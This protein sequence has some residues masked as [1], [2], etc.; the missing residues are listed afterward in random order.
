[1]KNTPRIPVSDKGSKYNIGSPYVILTTDMDIV[2][3]IK[4][5]DESPETIFLS[6][7]EGNLISL[8]EKFDPTKGSGDEAHSILL[9]FL[10]PEGLFIPRLTQHSMLNQYKIFL[11]KLKDSLAADKY[12]AFLP[13]TGE[14]N[15]N[16]EI[17][18]L[19]EDEYKFLTGKDAPTY[20][21]SE[22]EK[23]SKPPY[24]VNI[25]QVL[26]NDQVSTYDLDSFYS[27]SAVPPLH[28]Y[29][30]FGQGQDPTNQAPFRKFKIVKFVLVQDDVDN[31]MVSMTLVP[32]GP[33]S[34]RSIAKDE[35]TSNSRTRNDAGGLVTVPLAR[36]VVV[37]YNEARQSRMAMNN[38]GREIPDSHHFRIGRVVSFE[39]TNI[40]SILNCLENLF[41]KLLYSTSV[42]KERERPFVFLNPRLIGLIKKR[43]KEY[44][45]QQTL[46]QAYN[47]NVKTQLINFIGHKELLSRCG[48]EFVSEI[49]PEDRNVLRYIKGGG[50]GGSNKRVDIETI[51]MG[52]A[53]DPSKFNSPIDF[54]YSIISRLY[55]EV[56]LKISMFGEDRTGNPKAIDLTNK[57][58]AYEFL[59]QLCEQSAGTS[60]IYPELENRYVVEAKIPQ[61]DLKENDKNIYSPNF[62]NKTEYAA[63]GYYNVYVLTDYE[64]GTGIIN[65][66]PPSFKES[67]VK[68]YIKQI[69]SIS[70]GADKE[71]C[72]VNKLIYVAK[73]VPNRETT[74]WDSF[75]P[76]SFTDY[77]INLGKI[78][79]DKATGVFGTNIPDEFGLK[80]LSIVQGVLETIP[81]FLFNV[82]HSNVHSVV[83]QE[84]NE[85]LSQ[86]ASTF[87]ILQT[88]VV[89]SF[90]DVVYGDSK[91][92]KTLE[93]DD[94]LFEQVIAN[95]LIAGDESNASIRSL[96]NTLA[97]ETD[98]E[99]Q[100]DSK[101]VKFYKH[102]KSTI[103]KLIEDSN[104]TTELEISYAA[105]AS[106]LY[107]LQKMSNIISIAQ[108]S[109]EANFSK[110][111][112]RWIKQPA[113]FLH[114]PLHFKATRRAGKSY[115][116][117][118]YLILG[119]EHIITANDCYSKFNIQRMASASDEFNRLLPKAEDNPKK[120]GEE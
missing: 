89:E 21:T 45:D 20:T 12:K 71:Y 37:P 24:K 16:Y 110:I 86:L 77:I 61:Q 120:D 107:F 111:A 28:M 22:G 62:K 82:Q 115:V 95:S 106:Q 7:N 4:D 25:N 93:F 88:K 92:P 19:T 1:M 39:Y 53:Y 58:H 40:D 33:Q 51:S 9:K 32:P 96:L 118:I 26:E 113:L 98:Q 67:V 112:P 105:M 87:Q 63:S 30:S 108:I 94:G 72:N 119:Y 2:N 47:D 5:Y 91:K 52:I 41:Q 27:A 3:G 29:L 78:Y 64:V 49:R 35:L 84:N 83:F 99:V 80:Q 76:R 44:S 31:A 74:H 85:A 17:E 36:A 104:Y 54:V 48:I 13:S 6:V 70:K 103:R 68:E 90:R 10:D 81:K 14:K 34:E 18:V 109:T 97:I 55:S 11:D 57:D 69:S 23:K 102:L 15:P 75:K 43:A 38:Q 46:Y 56:D 8:M 101:L 50:G 42:D 60:F 100:T 116:S 79:P 73:P 59:K 114:K 117:G 65:P 66:L